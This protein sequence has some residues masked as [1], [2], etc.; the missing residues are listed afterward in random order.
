MT[1]SHEQRARRYVGWVR[2][3]ALA[4]IA[5]HALLV[6]GAIYLIAFHLPLRADFSYLLP[7]DAASVRDL[8]RLEDRVKAGDSVLVVMEA[9]DAATRAAAAARMVAGIRR[10]PRE[11]V[12]AVEADDTELRAF[13]SPRRHLYAPYEDLVRARDALKRRIEQAKL[14]SNPLF[15]ELDDDAPAAARPRPGSTGPAT[16]RSTGGSRR[17]RSARRSARPTPATASSSWPRWARCAPRSS[18]RTPASGS[19]S[20]AA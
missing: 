2:A 7:D 14:R 18:P 9:P 3:H 20:P 16:S 19:G 11:L 12:E 10:A 5:A 17:S 4:I 8:R 6:A 15:I 1:R 13:L